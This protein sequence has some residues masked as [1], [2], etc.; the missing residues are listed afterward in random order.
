MARDEAGPESDIDL[1][2][3]FENASELTLLDLARLES[4]LSSLLGRKVE[5]IQRGTF[6]DSI[7][8]RVG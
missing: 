5:L 8:E 1:E 6:K 7:R 4:R 3:A 2:A